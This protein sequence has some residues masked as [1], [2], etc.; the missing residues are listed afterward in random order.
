MSE[1]II[2]DLL[3]ESYEG[4][5]KYATIFNKVNLYLEKRFGIQQVVFTL[6]IASFIYNNI[7]FILDVFKKEVA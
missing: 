3:A 4:G 7:D 5:D 1:K 2:N 6:I